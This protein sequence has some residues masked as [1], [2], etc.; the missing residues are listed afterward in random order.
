MTEKIEI[1]TP[2]LILRPASIEAAPEV[3]VAKEEMW[4]EL[5]LWMSWAYDEQKPLEAMLDVIRGIS[6]P[7]TILW[8]FRRDTGEF[9]VTTGVSENKDNPG[10]YETGY[11]CAKAHLGQGFATEATNA[12]IRYA[13]GARH[14]KAVTIHYYEGHD[15]SRRIIEKLRFTPMGVHPKSHKRCSDGVL[16]DSHGFIRTSLE[17]L[18]ELDVSW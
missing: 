2:R 6:D 3:Q 1:I 11:W 16:L 14:A 15:K 9:A 12:A 4:P 8:G 18:P 17:G 10:T 5:Q 13:F 7:C